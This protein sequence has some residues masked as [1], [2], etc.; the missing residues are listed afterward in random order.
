MPLRNV[1]P[2]DLIT[3]LDWNGLITLVN[4][5][6]V[7]ITE[8]E[9]G[10]ST[11]D[12]RNPQITQ[13]QPSGQ[14]TAGDTINIFGSNFDFLTGGHSVFFGSTRA[15]VFLTG[16]SDTLLIVRIPDPVLGA[17]ETGTS[18]VMTVGN[19]VGTTSWPLTIRSLPVVTT[20]GF[21]FAYQGS[22]PTTPAQNTPILYDFQLSSFASEDL[23]I[24]ITPTI[25]VIP[26]LPGGVLAT[27]AS[28]AAL[29]TVLDSDGTTRTNRQISLPEGMTKM[30]SV[31]L[32]L[33]N[34]VNQLRYSLS[35]LAS[36][37]GVTS[38]EE[39]LPNQQVGQLAEQPDATVTNFESPTVIQ[40]AASFSPS[41]G[42]VSGVDGTISMVRGATATIRMRTTF[43][44]IPA[45][46]TNRYALTA[47]VDPPSGGWSSQ[48]NGIMQNPLEVSS[49]GG[50]VQIFFD[51]QSSNVPAAQAT[52][53][54]TL[55]R[56]GA[57]TGNT[58]TVAYRLVQS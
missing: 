50:L 53:R 54:L 6:D 45:A 25:Q 47:T 40:G 49:P 23:V 51:I 22:R 55:T 37:P 43:A 27:D 2:G 4:A 31:R 57:A 10:G 52:M 16:S 35:A 38:V 20:G 26:P 46:T 13:V 33:P 34:N 36:A 19:L 41:T 3:A 5:M 11:G 30:I 18:M 44:N 8:L 32:A 9:N 14:V 39:S 42:G 1:N 28:L 17:T 58:R 56:E 29:L 7:R 21:Q 24:T 48:V 12:P 15:T